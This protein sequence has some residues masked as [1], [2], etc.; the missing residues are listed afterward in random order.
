MKKVHVGDNGYT[1][2]LFGKKLPKYHPLMDLLGTIDELSSM[3][4]F[5]RALMREKSEFYKIPKI[6]LEI[7]RDLIRLGRD[8][9]AMNRYK[10][11][12]D[13]INENDVRR[14]EELINEFWK[15]PQE[16]F[17]IPG[18][19]SLYSALL[20]VTRAICRRAERIAAKL[21]HEEILNKYDY[22]YLNRLSD[23]LF[24]LAV[25]IDTLSNRD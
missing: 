12:N 10:E 14:L 8:V 5:A 13:Y 18:S 21:L 20:H 24:V 15:K 1:Y 4:G 23:L 9:A 2:I 16:N 11:F 7:Q 6:I 19:R 17:Q 25:Y 3:L 22:I